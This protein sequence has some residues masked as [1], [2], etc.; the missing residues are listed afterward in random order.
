M[1][2]EGKVAAITGAGSGMGRAMANLFA[3][4]GAKVVAADWNQAALDAVVAEVIA[5][6]GAITGVQGD[7]AQVAT[8]EAIVGAATGTFG[9]LDVLCNN[10]GVMDDFAGVAE[11]SDAMLTRVFGI[12]VHGPAYLSRLAVPRMI[13]QGGGSIVNTAS[14]AGMHGGAA[15]VVY[16]MSK[17]ACVGLTRS[18]A[19]HYGKQGVRCNAI[20]AGAVETNIM[21]SVD[22]SK[23][24]PTGA[25][26]AGIYAGIIPAMLKPLDI[27]H[28]A[29]YLASD[30]SR[31]ING[32]LIPAD[33]GWTAA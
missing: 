6:G 24:N 4:E 5:A 31:M 30:E 27:A 17:H 13:A 33:A 11:F 8:C 16:T 7:V 9:R 1:R 2:L 29:L 3:A 14:V 22:A 18:T 23:L 15:G 20:I 10:A 12:N 32:A 26:V 19:W 25:A 28:L 21:A